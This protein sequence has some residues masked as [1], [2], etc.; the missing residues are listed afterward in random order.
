MPGV[1]RAEQGADGVGRDDDGEREE[2]DGDDAQGGP[3]AVRVVPTA[4]ELPGDGRSSCR[5]MTA[6]QPR[7]QARWFDTVARLSPSSVASSAG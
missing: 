2:G 6:P 3:L 7:A 1:A 4:G 5:P